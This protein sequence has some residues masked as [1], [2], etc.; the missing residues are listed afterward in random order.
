MSNNIYILIIA[1]GLMFVVIGG[2]SI[3][4]HYYTLNGI[5]SRTVGD[6][7]HGTARFATKREIQK[8]YSRVL[9]TPQE[10]REGMN[11]PDLQG[12]VL[13]C[14][15]HK[16]K[17]KALVDTG[18]VH[19]LMIGASG[20]GKTAFFLYPNLEFACASGMSFLVTD[21]KGDVFRNY[22]VIAKDCYG[23]KVA[24]I[25]LRNPTR[26]DGNNLLHLVN[27]YMDAYAVDPKDI[28]SKAKAEK[29]AK[30]I[31]RTIISKS[32][33]ENY[34]Q[35]AFF[36]DAAEGVLTAVILLV[37]EYLQPVE[38][39]KSE[40]RHI[41]SVFKLVQE[42][43]APSQ[44][45][46]RNQFQLLMEKLPPEHKAKWFA[47]AALNTS[48]QAMASVMSTVLSRLNAFLDS[49]MEQILCFDTAIDAE[50]FCNEKSAIF[51]V[52]PEEDNTKYFMVSLM[53]QQLYR[54]ILAVADEKGGKLN[55]RAV[56]F[57]DEL[58]TI[59][60]IDSLELMFSASRSRRLTMVPIIQS[61]SQ[62]HKNYGR[63]GAEIIVDNCQDTIFGGFAP[64]SQTAEVLSK[65]LGSRTVMSG[66]ISR[67]KNDPTQ[68]LQMM[69][70]PL[71]TSDELK[72]L[73]KGYFIVMKTGVHPMKTRLR[74]FSEWGI[75]LDGSYSVPEKAGREVAYANRRE[76]EINIMKKNF[77]I[78]PKRVSDG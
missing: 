73:P 35:N 65:A 21:T 31:S 39:D 2:L 20:V 44:I 75:T 40:K 13:G 78:S 4:S 26:S 74:L 60:T 69:E 49:E 37:A 50:K 77:T 68:S 62:L 30:I 58:G 5:K 12:V 10:W 56:F 16:N 36:Y 72:A 51:I 55:K 19:T 3:L 8:T 48:E 63:E 54:E 43:L 9:F 71:L 46:G 17:L 53:I 57:C 6:G 34:G 25:D 15:G 18:D 23:Y 22:G 29:Y 47:G 32:G 24:V 14:V 28:V 52:L 66:S 64:N 7:Q 38:G 33:D 11:C 42:L 41:V 1:A 76:L 67:G 27:R 61:L 70:R 59:P 45:S